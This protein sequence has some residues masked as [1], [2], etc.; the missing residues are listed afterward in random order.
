MQPR[1]WPLPPASPSAGYRR[2]A[3]CCLVPA[4]LPQAAELIPA[5]HIGRRGPPCP[6]SQRLTQSTPSVSLSHASPCPLSLMKRCWN[7]WSPLQVAA[8][9]ESC[10]H[11]GWWWE[12]QCRG[13]Q[14]PA[15][16]VLELL[17]A[18]QSPGPS[19][20]P[21]GICLLGEE[22]WLYVICLWEKPFPFLC[23]MFIFLLVALHLLGNDVRLLWTSIRNWG[24]LC[25]MIP[26]G[27]RAKAMGWC[28][29]ESQVLFWTMKNL[30]RFFQQ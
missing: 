11:G 2:S 17:V 13:G 30:L 21:R 6:I 20:A 9:E 26:T 25:L 27:E 8:G 7:E 3:L 24:Y 14:R 23:G 19:R 1:L 22:L 18:L 12:E 5:L 4:M 16:T 15:I 28:T 29:G 10:G